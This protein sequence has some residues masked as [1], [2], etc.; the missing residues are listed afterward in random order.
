MIEAQELTHP[1]ARNV[2]II[3][4]QAP[5][6]TDKIQSQHMVVHFVGILIKPSK[7]KYLIVSTVRH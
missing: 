3:V 4:D 6:V 5:L 7:G 2:A 1:Y